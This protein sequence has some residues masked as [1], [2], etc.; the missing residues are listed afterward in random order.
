MQ[1]KRAAGE[2]KAS[3]AL[4]TRRGPFQRCAISMI[5][6]IVEETE[7]EA[8]RRPWGMRQTVAVEVPRKESGKA[9]ARHLHIM[10]P[11]IMVWLSCIWP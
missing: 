6:M 1:A 2:T 9:T 7:R 3:R 10:Y 4:C 11:R 5:G 8:G